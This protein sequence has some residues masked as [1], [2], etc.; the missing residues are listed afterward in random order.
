VQGDAPDEVTC[1]VEEVKRVMDETLQALR[2][3]EIK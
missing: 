3:G 2:E 1:W